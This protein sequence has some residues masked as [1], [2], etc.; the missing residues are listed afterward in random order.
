MWLAD[1]RCY[2]GA[3]LE[4]RSACTAVDAPICCAQSHK[5]GLSAFLV[6]LQQPSKMHE[7]R[8]GSAGLRN[9]KGSRWRQGTVPSHEAQANGGV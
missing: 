3:P 4:T 5:F 9:N 2:A 7:P 1:L 8:L 6:R